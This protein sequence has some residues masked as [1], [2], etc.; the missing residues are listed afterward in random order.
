MAEEAEEQEE[1]KSGGPGWLVAILLGVAGLGAGFGGAM[2]VMPNVVASE[3][4]AEEEMAESE[5]PEEAAFS[6]RLITLDPFVVNVSGEGYPRYLKVQVALELDSIEVKEDLELRIPQVRDLT[7][8][9][10]STKRLSDL[11]GFE[12]KALLKDDLRERINAL[13]EKGDVQSVLFTEF[14][15]Q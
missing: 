13:L 10:L 2:A 11:E 7:I 14:V 4:A 9:L 15:V 6:E 12:G 8:L 5:E 1:P 3:P